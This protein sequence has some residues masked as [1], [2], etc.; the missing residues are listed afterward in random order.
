MGNI[1]KYIVSCKIEVHALTPESAIE[2]AKL[3]YS[4][5]ECPWEAEEITAQ[6]ADSA[7]NCDHVY[8]GL[9]GHPACFECSKCKKLSR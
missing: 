7:D 3:T 5:R 8:V 1:K 2:C 4:Q 9:H 6:P